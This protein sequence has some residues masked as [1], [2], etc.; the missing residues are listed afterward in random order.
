MRTTSEYYVNLPVNA[1]K[2]SRPILQFLTDRLQV[3]AYTTGGSG[4]AIR[5]H[6]IRHRASQAARKSKSA[7]NAPW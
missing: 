4:P 7:G 6:E 3:Q 1:A 2:G 5:A